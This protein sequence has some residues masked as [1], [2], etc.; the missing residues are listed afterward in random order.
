[1]VSYK[2]AGLIIAIS[3]IVFSLLALVSLFYCMY[4]IYQGNWD[5]SAD[6]VENDTDRSDK[7]KGRS[8]LTK[9]ET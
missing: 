9:L 4:V 2:Y 1:M 7:T 8:N 5:Q 3:M 6:E